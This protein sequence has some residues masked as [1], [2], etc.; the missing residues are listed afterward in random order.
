MP[1]DRLAAIT[2]ARAE[3]ERAPPKRRTRF[4]P[5]IFVLRQKRVF[6]DH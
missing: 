6:G 3:Q 5:A 2:A 1:L 4:D